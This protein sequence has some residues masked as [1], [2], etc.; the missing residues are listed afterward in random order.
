MDVQRQGAGHAAAERLIHDK[1]QR[2]DVR[3]FITDDVAQN[4]TVEKRLDP[5]RSDLL[6]Q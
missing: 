3:Q 2:A 6:F 1:I 4:D 5:G